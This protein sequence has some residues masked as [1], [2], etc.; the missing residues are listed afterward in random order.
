MLIIDEIQ[1]GFGRTG[2]LW[3]FEHYTIIP[4][5]VVCAKGMGGGMPIGAFI[6]SQEKMSVLKENPMLGHITTFGGHPVSC[7]ASL[8]SLQVIQ[9]E[10]LLEGVEEKEALFRQSLQHEKIREIRSKGLMIAVE[11]DS[12]EVLKPIIDRSIE[13][14]VVTDWFLY[15]NTSM[16]I[17]PPLTITRDQIVEACSI[18]LESI[19]DAKV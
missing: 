13:K 12:F 19:K 9:Q 2:K 3:A 5:I 14:G 7:A 6:S 17:A 11:F 16:R 18:I 1:S 8:A 10:H 15:C 4:D